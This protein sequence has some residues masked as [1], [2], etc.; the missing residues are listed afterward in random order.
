MVPGAKSRSRV[1]LLVIGRESIDALSERSRD[2]GLLN[3]ELLSKH[4]LRPALAAQSPDFSK[5]GVRELG[6]GQCFAAKSGISPSSHLV[7]N[8]VLVRPGPQMVDGV[9]GRVVATVKCVMPWRQR[10]SCSFQNQAANANLAVI[11]RGDD[12]V[13]LFVTRS[14][15]LTATGHS[16]NSA[17]VE[18]SEAHIQGLGSRTIRACLRA[19]DSSPYGSRAYRARRQRTL[20]SSH[21]QRVAQLT[22]RS[23]RQVRTSRTE[24][25]GLPPARSSSAPTQKTGRLVK[26]GRGEEV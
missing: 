6:L 10:P 12:G 18:F 8:V 7:V 20:W 26:T 13:P 21:A 24:R 5:F 15:P 16:D 19:V 17:G 25:D 4:K 23:E 22:L 3:L 9:T 14:G 1:A 11:I 2:G